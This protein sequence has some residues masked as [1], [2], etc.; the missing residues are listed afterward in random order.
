M[1]SPKVATYDLQPE[2]SAPEVTDKL[3]E[4]IGS[5]R[6]DVVVVNYA[7]TDMVGHTGDLAAAIKAVE[8]VD[9]CLGRL[10]AA[11]EAAGR[12][13]RH[14]RRPRQCR[15]DAR[16]R[17]R[18]AAYRA[19]RSTRCRSSWSTRPAAIARVEQRPPRRC[20]ADA[21]RHPRACSKPAAMTGHSLI[22][23]DAS[24]C[25]RVSAGRS[26]G[27]P[28]RC[29][30]ADRCRRRRP[31]AAPRGAATRDAA[32]ASSTRCARNASP[33]RATRSSASRR[34][35]RS[36]TTLDLLGR[37]A[38]GRQRGLDESRAEQA[39][40]LGAIERLAR[41]SARA[42]SPSLAAAPI[43]RVRGELLLASGRRRRCAP[44]RAAL[45]RRDRADRG[46]AQAD[47]RASR[48]SS[49]TARDGARD[50]TGATSRS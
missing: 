38:A 16:P 50:R 27:S 44:R 41:A 23:A 18:R 8:A 45:V 20:R 24:A 14:H 3:V 12:H 7:N 33:P 28:R 15:D 31:C 9:A 37:D 43:D 17:D 5:G 2:M 1:P 47:R 25:G 30:A 29:A 32:P 21:A 40:L 26:R 22:V 35:R 48:A 10:A 19:Y 6:F 39:Q 46:A 4:A 11:V 36:N 34:S 13:A 49:T 42:R